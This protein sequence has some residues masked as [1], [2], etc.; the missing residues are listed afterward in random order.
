M[1]NTKKSKTVTINNERVT[2]LESDKNYNSGQTMRIK[3]SKG[4][5]DYFGQAVSEYNR[6]LRQARYDEKHPD[7]K[8]LSITEQLILEG[9]ERKAKLAAKKE[10]ETEQ[11]AINS[12]EFFSDPRNKPV[13]KNQK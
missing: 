4:S 3:S 10:K 9:K 11:F 13:S 2:I 7:K 5:R 8:H 12:R 1:A 6:T